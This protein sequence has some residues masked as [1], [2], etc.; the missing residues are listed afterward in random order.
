MQWHNSHAYNSSGFGSGF[1]TGMGFG[2]GSMFG[3]GRHGR[4]RW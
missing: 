3:P 4:H 1:G 2:S